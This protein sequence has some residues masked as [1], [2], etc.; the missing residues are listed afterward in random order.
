MVEWRFWLKYHHFKQFEVIQYGFFD[1][2]LFY[3]NFKPL[4]PQS[5][6]FKKLKKS[7]IL[8][9]FEVTFSTD[10]EN[11]NFFSANAPLI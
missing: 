10:W 2:I 6:V 9:K 5:S 8:K 11:N 1:K 4:K 3:I 7:E